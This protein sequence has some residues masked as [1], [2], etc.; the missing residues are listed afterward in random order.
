M[1][2]HGWTIYGL[3]KVIYGLDPSAPDTVLLA[4]T[5]TPLITEA[6]LD[7]LRARLEAP[8]TTTEWAV[9]VTS[10]LTG[11]SEIVPKPNEASARRA[12]WDAHARSDQDA[13][14]MT[15]EVTAW[16]AAAE[17]EVSA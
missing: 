4:R 2:A 14:V 10:R 7:D 1:S 5:D 17:S 11:R 9:Q 15:R 13:R 3:R 8:K 6:H 16:S 12:V